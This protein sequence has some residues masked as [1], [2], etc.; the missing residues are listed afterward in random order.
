MA[1]GVR[2]VLGPVQRKILIAPNSSDINL[3]RPDI[4]GAPVRQ[5]MGWQGK[6]VVM[7]FGAIGQANSLGFLV[8]VA[9]KMQSHAD[10]LFVVI[11]QGK[12][13]KELSEKISKLCLKNIELHDSTPKEE[14]PGLV[15]ACDVSTVIFGK[16]PI[17]EHNSANK[18]FDSLAAGK[19]VLL[20]Y[21]GWQR[22][23][24]EQY[25]AGLGCRLCDLNE[26]IENLKMLYGNRNLVR[27]MGLHA[28]RLAE[29][30]FS[31]DKIATEVLSVVQDVAKK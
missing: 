19:P 27:E 6:F 5:K 10:V 11:G 13:K 26:Y 12:E 30:E 16:Y 21:S 2:Q 31:R 25:N 18:F 7:H 29:K 9:Q 1:E 20:N 4:D 22:Q 23:V 15:A 28:R 17:L 14:M 3:F 24:L 8:G